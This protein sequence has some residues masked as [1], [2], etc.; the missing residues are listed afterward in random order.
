MNNI[1]MLTALAM[2]YVYMWKEGGCVLIGAHHLYCF[3][4]V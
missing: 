4:G 2:L 1:S 3:S